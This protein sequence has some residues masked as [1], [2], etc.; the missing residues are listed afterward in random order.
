VRL[1]NEEAVELLGWVRTGRH[2]PATKIVVR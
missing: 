2:G 1:R